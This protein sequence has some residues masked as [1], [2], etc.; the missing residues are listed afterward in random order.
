MSDV[1]N[2]LE[3]ALAQFHFN[4]EAFVGTARINGDQVSLPQQHALKHYIC[5]IWLFGSMVYAHQLQSQSIS[6]LS[7]SPGG[8]QTTLRH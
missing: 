1:L 3:G 2:K 4:R 8:A 5:S 7:R 6:R